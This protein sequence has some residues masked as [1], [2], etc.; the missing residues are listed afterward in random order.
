MKKTKKKHKASK[1]SGKGRKRNVVPLNNDL[2]NAYSFLGDS[3]KL[4]KVVEEN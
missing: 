1:T 2:A 3:K 4:I